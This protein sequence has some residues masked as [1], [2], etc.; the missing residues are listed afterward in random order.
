MLSPETP[1]VLDAVRTKD[2]TKVVLRITRT[3]T[4]ELSLGKLLCDLVLL[5]DP[6]NHTVPILDIIPIPDDE[7]KR[8][9]MVMPML[10]DFY[11]PPFHCRSEFVDALRQ[12]LEAGT[13]SM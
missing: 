1:L 7:E 5:Q 8:V 4:N 9:F 3:D 10:K 2:K 11:A 13:I 12:L 6:R